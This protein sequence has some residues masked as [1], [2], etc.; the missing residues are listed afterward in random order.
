MYL[1]VD[2]R[3]S[4]HYVPF[5][6]S[7][8]AGAIVGTVALAVS[9]SLIR[10]L[11]VNNTPITAKEARGL[12]GITFGTLIGGGVIAS[13]VLGTDQNFGGFLIG[14]ASYSW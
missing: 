11:V 12:L 14:E 6:G 7:I 10:G 2:C 13:F 9:F 5:A 1:S 8:A 3:L 4:M